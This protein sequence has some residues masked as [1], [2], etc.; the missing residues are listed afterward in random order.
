MAN[1]INSSDAVVSA[2]LGFSEISE[3][4]LQQFQCKGGEIAGFRIR[5]LKSGS[6]DFYISQIYDCSSGENI[7][8]GSVSVV[9]GRDLTGGL[10]SSGCFPDANPLIEGTIF[11]KVDYI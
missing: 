3:D 9:P 10:F 2:H 8:Q 6:F 5:H 4:S 7:L 1:F 11:Y